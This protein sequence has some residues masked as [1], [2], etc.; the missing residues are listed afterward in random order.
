MP[1]KPCCNKLTPNSM[2]FF[3]KNKYRKKTKVYLLPTIDLPPKLSRISGVGKWLSSRFTWFGVDMIG[4][5]SYRKI[6]NNRPCAI[7]YNTSSRIPYLGGAKIAAKKK[8]LSPLRD[9]KKKQKKNTRPC[10]RRQLQRHST[11]HRPIIRD[12][13]A[14]ER[15]VPM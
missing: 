1:H 7:P 6:S 10:Q 15:G 14:T 9:I 12:F 4:G 13:T 5:V 11:A 2:N 8:L 3:F